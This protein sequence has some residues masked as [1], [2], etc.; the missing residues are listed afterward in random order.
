MFQ[1]SNPVLNQNTFADGRWGGI[2]ADLQKSEAMAR[3]STMT[4]RGTAIKTLFLLGLAVASAIGT[5]LWMN[6]TTQAGLAMPILAG[7]GI[8]ALVLSLIISFAQ[9][10]APFLAPVYALVKG[11]LLGAITLFF[12]KKYPGIATMAIAATL[13]V[14]GG[15]CAAYCFGLIRIGST[16]AKVI[17]AGV[18]GVM[19]LY[20]AQMVAGFMGYQLLSSVHGAGPIGLAFSG[21]VLVLASL[22]LVWAFQS[23]EEGV[24]AGAPKYMEWYCGFGILVQIAWLYLEIL[25]LLAKLRQR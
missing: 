5:A 6:S 17:I 20:L 15:L 1:S 14:A 21:V 25:R 7:S 13:A 24:Q 8:G 23:V 9:K 22:S 10:T 16:L 19:L 3:S 11:V 18:T 4:I 2:M 12:E